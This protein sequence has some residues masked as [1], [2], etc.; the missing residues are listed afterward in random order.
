MR[1][2]EIN[3]NSK[4]RGLLPSRS[5][6]HLPP[7]GRLFACY[8]YNTHRQRKQ[9]LCRNF[10]TCKFS[11]KDNREIRCT[12][13]FTKKKKVPKKKLATLQVDRRL[14][15]APDKVRQLMS[16]LPREWLAEGFILTRKNFG[17]EGI[18]KGFRQPLLGIFSLRVR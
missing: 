6:C 13:F 14:T 15:R 11:V 1:Y 3:P 2:N 8:H 9:P 12:F 5:A 7:G 4:S 16:A 17:A 18:P 10:C